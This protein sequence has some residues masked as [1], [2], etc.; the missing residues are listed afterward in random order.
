MSAEP[1]DERTVHHLNW[2]VF[3]RSFYVGIYLTRTGRS[4]APFCG[5]DVVTLYYESPSWQQAFPWSDFDRDTIFNAF[6]G[7]MDSPV[8]LGVAGFGWWTGPMGFGRMVVGVIWT[9]SQRVL[10]G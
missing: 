3:C 10:P 2:A 6:K 1:R 4:Y 8:V 5:A 9:L 7:V